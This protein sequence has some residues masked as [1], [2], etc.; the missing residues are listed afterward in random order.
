[1]TKIEALKIARGMYFWLV[2]HNYCK[3]TPEFE[4]IINEM[5]RKEQLN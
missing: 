2:K 3:K 1:M 5:I 4:K